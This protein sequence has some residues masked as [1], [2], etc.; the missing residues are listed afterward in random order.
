MKILIIEDEKELSRNISDYLSMENYVCEQA[1]TFGEAIDKISVYTYDCILLDLNLPGG[2]GLRILNEIGKQDIDSGVIIISAR[3]TLDDRIE[4]LK[5]GAD[6]YLAKPFPLP[7]LRMR[8]YALM[9]RRKFTNSN[10]LQSGNVKIDLLTKQVKTPDKEV[11]LTKSEY[12]LL[13]FL[14]GNKN[15]VVSKN[16][17]AEHLSGDMADM[18]DNHNFVYAHVK[19]L[20]AKL[21]DAGLSNN[22]KTIY[23]TGYQWVE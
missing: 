4:G 1:F 19:N 8:I 13:L 12:E 17:I 9:R 16:A 5:T 3:G 6:D 20:K 10:T 2:D 21:A 14:I 23:G 15:R 11:V 18:L 22:I 7:E